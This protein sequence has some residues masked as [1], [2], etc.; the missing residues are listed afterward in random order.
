MTAQHS[1][2]KE[3]AELNE[4]FQRRDVEAEIRAAEEAMRRYNRG[5]RSV[6][7]GS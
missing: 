6:L 2:E 4:M 1:S 3:L 7:Y 5:D